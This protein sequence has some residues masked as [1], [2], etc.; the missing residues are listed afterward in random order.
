MCTVLVI[1]WFIWWTSNSLQGQH[2][3]YTNELPCIKKVQ[4]NMKYGTSAI[5]FTTSV[6]VVCDCVHL[7][8]VWFMNVNLFFKWPLNQ[9]PQIWGKNCYFQSKYGPNVLWLGHFFLWNLISF[10]ITCVKPER[11][12]YHPYRG[13]FPLPH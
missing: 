2:R 1:L 10:A 13:F 5:R 9:F 7:I 6:K 8:S 4:I 3:F 11:D 12:G